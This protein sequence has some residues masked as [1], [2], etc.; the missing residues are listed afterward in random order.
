MDGKIFL[1]TFSDGSTK[2]LGDYEALADKAFVLGRWVDFE[3][4]SV[5]EA[6]WEAWEAEEIVD[7]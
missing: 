2:V 6:K 7:E 5:R 1:A 3:D 4:K